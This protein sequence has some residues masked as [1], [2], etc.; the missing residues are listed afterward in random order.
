MV[1]WDLMQS[2]ARMSTVADLEEADFRPSSMF[3]YSMLGSQDRENVEHWNRRCAGQGCRYWA[4]VGESA[5]HVTLRS[6]DGTVRQVN[7]RDIADLRSLF[8]KDSNVVIDISGLGHD[9]WS[10]CLVAL[11]GHVAALTYI[12]TEPRE[13]QRRPE[14]DRVRPF[15]LFDLSPSTMGPRHL[16]GFLS[17]DDSGGEDGLFVPL[18]G[19]EGHRAMNL[20]NEIEP[21]PGRTIPVIGIPGYQVEFPAYTAYC[22]RDLFDGTD[23]HATWRSAPASDPFAVKSVLSRIRRDYPN[24]YMHIAPIGTRPHALGALLYV[25]EE[26]ALCEILFD[27]PVSRKGSRMGRGPS[28][29][30]CIVSP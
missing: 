15:D 28:H 3:V 27:R 4:A 5:E 6:D 16:S 11:K 23:S 19:F 9:F 10:G 17:L 25:Q 20:L 1:R 7:V 8:P 30:Y 29:L 22:N 14:P 18:L 12:Y 21:G 26:P 13:Y 2:A 24:H